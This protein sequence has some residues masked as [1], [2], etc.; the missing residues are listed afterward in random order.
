MDH[1]NF[2]IAHFN[3]NSILAEG[4][5][6]ELHSICK[7]LNLA[8]LCITESK[9]DDT[10]PNNIITIEGYYEPLRRDRQTNGRQG[11]GCLIYISEQLTYKHRDDL[12]SDN[13]EHLWA[14]VKVG[15]LN[16]TITTFYRP[17]N[18]STEDHDIFLSTAE[19]IL[20]NLCNHNT[21]NKIIASDLNFGNLYCKDPKL[22]P[23]PLDRSA[24]DLFASYGF[25]QLIDIPTRLTATSTSLIDLIFVQN[26]NLIT[27]YG[28]LQPIAD[29]EGVILCMDIKREQLPSHSKTI[30]D[31][32][33]ADV[34]GLISYIK[35]TNFD[36]LVFSND[37]LQQTEIY[38]KILVTA[39]NKFVPTITFSVKPTSPPWCNSYTRLLLR[40]KNRNY[41]LFKKASRILGNTVLNNPNNE[42]LIT[43]LINRKNKAHKNSR[44]A[45]NESLKANRR[46]KDAFYNSVNTTMNN[47]EIP[48]KKKSSILLKFSSI[49]PLLE[50]GHTITDPTQKRELFNKHFASKSTVPNSGDDVPLLPKKPHI[51]SFDQINTS[52][53]E[54]S[55]MLRDNL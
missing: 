25:T 47:H 34:E 44:V 9:L 14:D 39:F 1:N 35:N 52:P 5:L 16:L 40:K 46:V 4:R 41:G 36:Q 28:S 6:D 17:P 42:E 55:K 43:K 18:E 3:V 54:L 11:G 8:V 22:S 37:V 32:K 15:S 10:I 12:Q 48:S 31:Y 2:K 23:K 19:E 29:H 45:A 33:N 13:F 26:E 27:E 21:D 53:I 49:P 24:P 30:F 20:N 51:P 50:N 7:L 38:S